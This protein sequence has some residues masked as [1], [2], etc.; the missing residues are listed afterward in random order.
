MGPNQHL[1][2]VRFQEKSYSREFR[3]FEKMLIQVQ[4]AQLNCAFKTYFK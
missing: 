2:I 1:K 3:K 4:D